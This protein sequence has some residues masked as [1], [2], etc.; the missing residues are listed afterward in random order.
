MLLL[1]AWAVL[2]V[3]LFL[4]PRPKRT[5]RDAATAFCG[6][7]G[8]RAFVAMRNEVDGRWISIQRLPPGQALAIDV[9]TDRR[10]GFRMSV[11]ELIEL[12][13]NCPP[14]VKPQEG[15]LLLERLCDVV[16]V[17]SPDWKIRAIMDEATWKSRGAEIVAEIRKELRARTPSPAVPEAGQ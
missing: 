3:I 13:K 14:D 10:T 2:V 12:G 16:F 11:D 8:D 1:L 7:A 6:D 15:G 4:W 17:V 9:V 5:V